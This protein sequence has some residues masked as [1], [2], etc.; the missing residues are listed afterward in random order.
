M[1]SDHGIAALLETLKP[2]IDKMAS[3]KDP[4]LTPCNEVPLVDHHRAYPTV[5]Y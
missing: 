1:G 2:S 3:P 5:T 4:K